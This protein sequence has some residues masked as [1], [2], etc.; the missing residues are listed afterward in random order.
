[1]NPTMIGPI[2][3]Q[4]KVQGALNPNWR[5]RLGGMQIS[6]CTQEDGSAQTNLSGDL[7][8]Q[9]ALLGILNAL[10]DMQYPLI[11]VDCRPV[12]T[13]LSNQSQESTQVR[14]EKADTDG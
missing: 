14:D 1:M 10:Y 4:A 9:A 11:S 7:M 5:G 12:S 8:D 3:C 2:H 13:A 6:I